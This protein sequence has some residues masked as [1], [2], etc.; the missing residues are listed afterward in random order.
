M[1]PNS[2]QH[3]SVAPMLDLT[4]K[5]CRVFHRKLSQ[6]TWLYSEMV[7]T[8]AILF[9]QNDQ[10]FLGKDDSDNPVV[11][12][13]G[14]SVVSEM[15]QCA[16]K[17]EQWGYD[18]I[19]INVGCPSDRV[20]NN[21][22]GACLMN[23]PEVVANCVKAMKDAVD[24]PVTVKCR[25]GIDDQDEQKSIRNMLEHLIKASVDGVIIH[26]RK[27]WLQGLSPKENRHV[28][29][30]NYALVQT[31][32]EEYPELAIAIN[33]GI[34]SLEQGLEI[35]NEN[36]KTALDG[37]MIGRTAYE[38][39]FM[40]TGVDEKV[41]GQSRFTKSR[42]QI[43]HEMIPYI[44]SH[45]ENGGKL[46]QITRHMLGLYHGLPGGRM[47]RRHLS[48]QAFKKSATSQTVL[49]ALNIVQDEICRMQEYLESKNK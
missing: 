41:Y 40:L 14:G 10:R 35:C 17:G 47:W 8:G 34:Q 3:F 37:F 16:Q 18:E 38:Q 39:P 25:I 32:K 19:N 24:I 23:T 48:Q 30:L 15:V 1:K 21:A 13:L 49:D 42:E 46:I 26:A 20:Q 29:P 33:G 45:I 22:I 11:L 4:D 27:A 12:Q 28:P 31:V 6:K 7:T 43:V 9:G 5:H 36:K 44:D 2:A